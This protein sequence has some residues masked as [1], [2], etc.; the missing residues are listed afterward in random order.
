MKFHAFPPACVKH[1]TAAVRPSH[2][3]A[4]CQRASHRSSAFNSPRVF[5]PKNNGSEVLKGL[6][7]FAMP[8][9]GDFPCQFKVI[10]G[11]ELAL[12]QPTGAST[13]SLTPP[14]LLTAASGTESQQTVRSQKPRAFFWEKKTYE[15]RPMMQGDISRGHSAWHVFLVPNT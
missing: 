15:R 4:Q 13:G 11:N 12:I 7:V 14:A 10:L 5:V 1:Q 9:S 6:A 3:H 8:R 2:C